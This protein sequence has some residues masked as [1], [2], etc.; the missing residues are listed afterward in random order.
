MRI[1]G[2]VRA[3]L[4]LACGRLI[5]VV[6]CLSFDFEFKN[7]ELTNISKIKSL[8]IYFCV[9]S[10]PKFTCFRLQPSNNVDGSAA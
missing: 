8:L 4:S 2:V 9:S 10:L 5:T 7:I 6:R 1:L 3:I